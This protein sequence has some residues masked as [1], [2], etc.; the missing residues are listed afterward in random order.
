MQA[1][2]E[3]GIGLRVLRA[4]LETGLQLS[5]RV[6]SVALAQYCK[7]HPTFFHYVAS[8]NESDDRVYA[9]QSG[10]RGVPDEWHSA[11]WESGDDD[12]ELRR[13]LAAE[14]IDEAVLRL[15]CPH[16]LVEQGV[17][18]DVAHRLLAHLTS[19]VGAEDAQG[20]VAA[21][22]AAGSAEGFVELDIVT[23][24]A[25]TSYPTSTSFAALHGPDG[26]RGA[27]LGKGIGGRGG[28]GGKGGRGTC[29][30]ATSDAV[31]PASSHT[32][33]TELLLRA[34]VSELMQRCSDMQLRMNVLEE[35]RLC[36]ICLDRLRDTIVLP[37][38]HAMFCGSC[39]RSSSP[40]VTHCPTCRGFI[41]GLLECRLDML[42][43]S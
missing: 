8:E 3:D 23:S 36:T 38:M 2:G 41:S 1:A 43:E 10:G 30:L 32:T 4:R 21:G 16:D 19:H 33:V 22:A 28:R 11:L 40:P 7:L 27:G 5:K 15:M 35:A 14:G 25:S 39:L 13:Q 42:E 20:G 12:D 37:C 31:E 17:P 24:A 26:G 18:L 9:L 34:K 6:K 29:V